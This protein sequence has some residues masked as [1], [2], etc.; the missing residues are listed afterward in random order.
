MHRAHDVQFAD[1]VMIVLARAQRLRD[2]ADHLA[3]GLRRGIGDPAHQPY[4][5]APIDQA[6]AA[7]GE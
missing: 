7:P 2:D 3:T 4:R 1:A 5:A 6:D